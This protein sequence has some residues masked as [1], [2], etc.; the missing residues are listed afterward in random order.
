MRNV[1]KVC[2]LVL[3]LGFSFQGFATP[4]GN[5]T[6][7]AGSDLPL[8][9]HALPKE[10]LTASPGT[11][12]LAH[13][14]GLNLDAASPG[15][16]SL[17]PHRPSLTPL[18]LFFTKHPRVDLLVWGDNI[19]DWVRKIAD[20]LEP[21]YDSL[22]TYF[23][24][25]PKKD[26]LVL[27]SKLSGSVKGAAVTVGSGVVKAARVGKAVGVGMLKGT[28]AVALGTVKAV[29]ATA[30]GVVKVARVA[31]SVGVGTIKAAKVTAS[32]VVKVSKVTKAVALGTV[33]AAKVVG[34][35]TARAA[36]AIGSKIGAL[37]SSRN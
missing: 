24:A 22:A 29:K 5:S 26:P 34:S 6:M 27:L 36:G 1:V 28:K 12:S 35:S 3:V 19:A 33:K 32:G 20:H 11:D 37:S 18:A 25:N 17:I 7:G 4:S 13:H 23:M 9:H 14:H 15:V 2:C 30:S 16:S 31:K 8:P 10:N 21:S